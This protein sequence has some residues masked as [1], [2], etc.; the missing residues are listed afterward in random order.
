VD[1]L[2]E[3][4]RRIDAVDLV[5]V[6]V[7]EAEPPE[8]LIDRVE[9]VAARQPGVVDALADPAAHL[10]RDHQ[11]A[12]PHAEPAQRLADQPLALALVVDVGGVEEVDAGVERRAQLAGDGVD[13]ELADHL[14]EALAA[15]GHGAEAQLRD[16]EAG[17]AEAMGAH[18][19][20]DSS[21][22]LGP[23]RRRIPDF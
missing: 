12:A 23:A 22:D 11:V 21:A 20:D 6:D 9:D 14:P 16:V 1:R 8:A 5:Q 7:I 13:A 10:G 17:L 19:A 15:V 4:R 3:R 2:L 18:G